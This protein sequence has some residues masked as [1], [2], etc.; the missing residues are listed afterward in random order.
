MAFVFTVLFFV[1]LFGV[2]RPF[3][4]LKRKHFGMAAFASFILIGV[5]APASDNGTASAAKG[6]QTALSPTQAAALERENADQIVLLS[7]RA[8]ALPASDVDRNLALYKQLSALAPANPNYVKKVSEFEE[9]L[10]ARARYEDHP[11]EALTIEDFDWGT[12]GFGSIME[13]S[14]LTVKNDAPFAIKDFK[15]HCVHQGNSGTD[16][17]RN[18]RV[19]FEVV[20]ASSKKTFRDINMGFISSQAKTS[21]CEIRSAVKV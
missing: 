2:F 4:G 19:L 16:M 6:Q 21:N 7:K 8:V 14:R 11:A 10:E 18:T 12:G 17:D 20:P 9:K 3:K 15:L 13:I 5:T 1:S